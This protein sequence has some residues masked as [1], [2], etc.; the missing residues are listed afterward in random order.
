MKRALSS[1]VRAT[2]GA[3]ASKT[4]VGRKQLDRNSCEFGKSNMRCLGACNRQTHGIT[5]LEVGE[6][7]KGIHMWMLWQTYVPLC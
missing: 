7:A 2:S 5:H 4:F 6:S 3:E 1:H